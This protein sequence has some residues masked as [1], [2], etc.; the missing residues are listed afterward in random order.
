MASS[1]ARA[2]DIKLII[3]ATVG[4]LLAGFLIAGAA[5]V[6]TRSKGSVVCGQLNIGSATDVRQTLQDGGP[7]FQTG[8]AGCGFWLALEDGDIV[9]YKVAQPQNC[10]LELKRDHWQCGSS[11]VTV[12]GLTRYPVSIQTVGQTDSVIIDLLPP[13]VATSTTSST[14][15]TSA[16]IACGQLDIG[17]ETEVRKTLDNGGPYFQTGGAGCG[18]WLA[19]DDGHI[20]AYRTDQPDNCTLKFTSN[21]WRCGTRTVGVDRLLRDKVTIDTVGTTD[22]V[23]VNF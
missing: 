1:R 17:K 2:S 20:V 11:T 4:V 5:F 10:S 23:L 12:D 13:G 6:A 8:G 14:V 7:Y 15:K 16:R 21:A 3:G 19:L 9:A 22:S 18:F